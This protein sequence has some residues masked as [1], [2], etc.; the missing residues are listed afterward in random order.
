MY[1]HTH[2][3]TSSRTPKHTEREAHT[4]TRSHLQTIPAALKR[5]Y[6]II[7]IIMEK[8]REENLQRKRKG[9]MTEKKIFVCMRL[10]VRGPYIRPVIASSRLFFFRFIYFHSYTRIQTYTSVLYNIH[11]AAYTQC[12]YDIPHLQLQLYTYYKRVYDTQ[13]MRP[14]E[15]WAC[16]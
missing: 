13:K 14:K 10:C 5:M 11:N 7:Q 9:K 12:V 1:L 15:K 6:E 3:N 2:T 16:D 4:L 8:K